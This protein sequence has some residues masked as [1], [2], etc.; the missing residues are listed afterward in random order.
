[1][2][3]GTP[4]GRPNLRQ[5]ANRDLVAQLAEKAS[6]LARAEVALAKAE[7][8]A[9]IRS[10]IRMASG[11]GVAGVCAIWTVSLLLVAAVL[12][13]AEAGWLPG[14]AAA[15]AVAAAVLLVGT[16]AGLV[17]WSK[18]VRTPLEKTRRTLQ[19][20]VKWAKERIA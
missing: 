13:I 8:R 15:L 19:D 5:L 18:R 20:N 9:D 10:E 6:E 16:I 11:L 2:E 14:W 12:G 1:M 17:G 7:V 3:G 4:S